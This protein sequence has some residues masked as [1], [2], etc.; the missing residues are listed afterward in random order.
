MFLYIYNI[1]KRIRS[2]VIIRRLNSIHRRGKVII[3]FPELQ[4]TTKHILKYMIIIKSLT[5]INY[6]FK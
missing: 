6:L 4:F 5:N 2:I 3:I 1:Y